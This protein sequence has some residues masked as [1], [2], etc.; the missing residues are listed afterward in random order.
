MQR[1][2]DTATRSKLISVSWTVERTDREKGEVVAPFL[3]SL[4]LSL[5]FSFWPHMCARTMQVCATSV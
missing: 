5:L 1:V 4:S 3:I 2:I